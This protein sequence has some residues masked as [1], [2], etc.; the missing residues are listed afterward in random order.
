MNPLIKTKTAG[1][2]INAN[3]IV[4]YSADSTVVQGAAAAD[5]LVG[6]SV[7]PGTSVASG[8][9]CDVVVLGLAKVLFGGTVA[10]GKPVTSDANGKAVLCAPAAGL[11]ESVIGYAQETQADGDIGEI[12]VCPSRMTTDKDVS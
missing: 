7:Q 8:E 9:R 1:G 6:V 11:T 5:E 12:L 10:R 2:T 3:R 4:K